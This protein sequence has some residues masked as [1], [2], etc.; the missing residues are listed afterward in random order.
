MH[1]ECCLCQ[2]SAMTVRWPGGMLE[3]PSTANLN[4]RLRQ[5]NKRFLYLGTLGHIH[6]RIIPQKSAEYE[7]DELSHCFCRKGPVQRGYTTKARRTVQ[8]F[9]SVASQRLRRVGKFLPCLQLPA[10]H[11]TVVL[12]GES[13]W[14]PETG[15]ISTVLL[16]TIHCQYLLQG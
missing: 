10:S 13:V 9:R 11:P 6:P 8:R 2:F 16:C 3:Q 5:K 12:G 7:R 14:W 15:I 1:P 4:L